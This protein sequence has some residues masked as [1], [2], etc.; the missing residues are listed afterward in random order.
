MTWS[1]KLSMLVLQVLL[2]L[3]SKQEG[4]LEQ[5]DMREGFARAVQ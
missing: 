5:V 2:V 4:S 1:A 3:L